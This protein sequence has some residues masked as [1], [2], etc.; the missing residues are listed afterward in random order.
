[1]RAA[2]CNQFG[3]PLAV[4][5]LVLDPPHDGEVAVQVAACGICH[6][7]LSFVEGA[8]DGPLPAVYGHEVA[9]TITEVGTGVETVKPGDHA[10]VT[11]IRSCGRCYFCLRG[12]VTQCAGVF[13][14]DQR[15]PLRLPGGDPVKQG[16]KVAGF[17]EHVTV[18]QSQAV[19]IPDDVPLD[20]ACL[21]ACAVA[22]GYGA[23]SN[24]AQVPAGASVAVVGAGGV[25]LNAIQGAAI[26]AARP[27]IAVDISDSRLEA[28]ARFGATHGVNSKAVDAREA[29]KRLT[30]GRGA[31]YTFVTSGA[32]AAIDLG[33]RLSRRGGTIVV[34]GMTPTGVTIAIDPGEFADR[35]LHMLGSKMG[36]TRP[37][38]DIP[39]MVELYR[40]GKLKLD[41]L[42]TGRFALD[43]I[44][45]G[46]TATRR[47]EGLR[48]VVIF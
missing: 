18:H 24:T 31:D 46:M 23:V 8:W 27:V 33:V 42:V 4:E 44:N 38:I 9:G 22:T 28:A 36:A 7:D 40:T 30:D 10:I 32:T 47:G 3:Q 14:I 39:K 35:A 20:S 19:R 34:V 12:E 41:E 5:Q 21:L 11:L 43:Q 26:A 13:E 16:L 17:A 1:M 37:Q 29:V 2:V 48:S 6:S 25:G 15:E 45:E